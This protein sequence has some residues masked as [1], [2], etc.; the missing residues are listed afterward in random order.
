MSSVSRIAAEYVNK[1]PAIY[2]D[3]LAAFPEVDPVRK[4][5]DGL[6]IQT[7]HAA[8][9]E[10]WSLGQIRAAAEEMGRRGVGEIQS[11][12]FLHPTDLGEAL[13]TKL[14][15][16]TSLELVPP[17]PPLPLPGELVESLPPV[18]ALGFPPPKN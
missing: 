2:R 8:L 10:R 7:I 13:I 11:R 1:L 4:R 12:I 16:I 6:A 14:T 5:G 15:G 9:H 17:L 3:I 18:P